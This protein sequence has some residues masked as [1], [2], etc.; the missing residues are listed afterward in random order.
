LISIFQDKNHSYIFVTKI[1]EWLLK[2]ETK[3]KLQEG[4]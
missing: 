4:Y 3:I 1:I 2:A